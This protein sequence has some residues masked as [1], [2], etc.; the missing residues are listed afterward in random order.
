MTIE[1]EVVKS[2]LE[3][4]TAKG[5]TVW[6]NNSGAVRRRGREE[7]GVLVWEITQMGIQG[8]LEKIRKNE[9]A[10]GD[11]TDPYN[12][13]DIV[14]TREGEGLNTKY[15]TFPARQS[16]PL[17]EDEEQAAEWCSSRPDFDKF[18]K[19]MTVEEAAALLAGDGE[20]AAPR[21]NQ[22]QLPGRSSAS[23]PRGYGS[24]AAKKRTAQDDLGDDD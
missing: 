5:H 21:S 20:D 2:L 9:D 10:G 15:T 13:F 6:R 22:R 3:Y 1:G 14:V 7:E 11:F 18:S 12:G 16:T 19:L 24:G 23:A 8:D 4:L 17:H